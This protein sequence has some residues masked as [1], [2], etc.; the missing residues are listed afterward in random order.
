MELGHLKFTFPL[1]LSEVQLPGRLIND[2]FSLARL[3]GFAIPV[4]ATC[5][6]G[7]GLQACSRSSSL[8]SPREPHPPRKVFFKGQ[9]NIFVILI[10]EVFRSSTGISI[11][12]WKADCKVTTIVTL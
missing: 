7:E 10:I 1:G 12:H 8:H 9:D 2:P 11:V 3:E 5:G 4:G 6:L